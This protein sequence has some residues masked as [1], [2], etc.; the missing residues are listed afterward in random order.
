MKKQSKTWPL[1]PITFGSIIIIGLSLLVLLI[2]DQA[3]RPSTS[4]TPTEST[5]SVTDDTTVPTTLPE[6]FP[7]LPDEPEEVMSY[8]GSVTAHDSAS[9][10]IQLS[11]GRGNK[12]VRY[13]EQTSFVRIDSPTP[14]EMQ[15]MTTV[16]ISNALQRETASNVAQVVSGATIRAVADSNIKGSA[17]FTAIKIILIQ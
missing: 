17:E 2:K 16:Q 1:V 13:T 6:T 10:T 14:E 3:P 15:T 11:T 8:A 12:T 5:S 4:T 9:G 7:P